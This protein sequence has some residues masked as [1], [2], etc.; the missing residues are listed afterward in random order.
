[1]LRKIYICALEVDAGRRPKVDNPVQA[2]G[3]ARGMDGPL[4]LEL[5]SSSPRSG[6]AETRCI[7]SLPRAAPAACTGL[8]DADAF[9]RQPEVHK[10]YCVTSVI[11][12][13]AQRTQ[14]K[15]VV[16]KGSSPVIARAKP[17]AIQ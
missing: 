4:L 14:R 15:E 5:R 11:N 1:M 16:S 13:K 7:A 12:T 9:R 2:A 8:S 10:K 3:A 17:E 6:V